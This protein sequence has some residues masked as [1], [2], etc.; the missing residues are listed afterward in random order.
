MER[1]GERCCGTTPITP[2]DSQVKSRQAILSIAR[3]YF[4]SRLVR[5]IGAAI[6]DPSKAAAA[7]RAAVIWRQNVPGTLPQRR[8]FVTVVA[9]LLKIHTG[10]AASARWCA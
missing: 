6:D 9:E 10:Y 1:S 7:V 8:A 4:P 3:E 5:N 2:A